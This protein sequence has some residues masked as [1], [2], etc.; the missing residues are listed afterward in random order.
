MSLQGVL[1]TTRVTL[2][3]TGCLGAHA[4]SLLLDSHFRTWATGAALE[5]FHVRRDLTHVKLTARY[6]S[7]ECCGL[8]KC[9]APKVATKSKKAAPVV[10][11][12]PARCQASA[13]ANSPATCQLPA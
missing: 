8:I 13:K 3:P 7:Q 2:G 12:L 9:R 10:L 5:Q 1:K 4:Q 6:R 11:R